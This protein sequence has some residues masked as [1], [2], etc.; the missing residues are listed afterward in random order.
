MAGANMTEIRLGL[1]L[2]RLLRDQGAA[3]TRE[4]RGYLSSRITLTADHLARNRTAVS[5]QSDAPI[6]HLPNV[7]FEAK[8]ARR[9]M[10]M[11]ALPNGI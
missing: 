4:E 10:A 1:R 11:K 5:R 6:C 8:L 2:A 9:R 7:T 3:T